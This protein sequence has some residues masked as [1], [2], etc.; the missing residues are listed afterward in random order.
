MGMSEKCE[1][2]LHL[3]VLLSEFF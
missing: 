1:V 3:K 2:F